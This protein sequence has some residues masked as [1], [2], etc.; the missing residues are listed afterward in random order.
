MTG[1]DK[2]S[3]ETKF[4]LHPATRPGTVSLTVADLDRQIDFYRQVIGLQ[5]HWREGATAG[6]GVGNADL[7]RLTAVRDARR[8]PGRTGMYHF[9]ILLPSRRELARALGRLFSLGYPNYPTDHVMTQTTY[10]DDPEGNNIE[11]Y[12]DTPEEGIFGFVNGQFVARRANGAPSS[13]RDP[14]D[15]EAL[16]WELTPEDRLDQPMPPET[17]MGH[18]HLYVSDLDETMR[19]YR[20]VLGFDDMGIARTFRMGMVSVNGYHHHIG[21]NTWVGQGASPPPAGALGLRHFSIVLPDESELDRVDER[22]Q[23]VGIIAEEM[24]GGLLIRDPSQNG[25]LLTTPPA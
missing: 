23:Q 9:A 21:F 14:L 16:L 24:A 15:V 12:A 3:P 20:D 18:V 25:V 10:L 13:G 22:I 5:L 2:L 7:L 11:L 8:Y 17:T 4:N 1:H 6:L 19:F